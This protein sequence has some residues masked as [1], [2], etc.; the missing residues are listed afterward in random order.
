MALPARNSLA[1]IGAGPVGLEAASVALDRGFDVHVFE[2]GE[3]GTHPL[4]WGHVRMFTP[5]SMNM[6]PSSRARL[7]RSGWRV[8]DE[9]FCPTGAELAEDYL[10][11]LASLPELKDRIHTGAQVVWVSRRGALKADLMGDPRRR[12]FPFRMI[13][14]DTGGREHLLHAYS[15]IDASGVFG[16]PNWAGD[17]GIP[18]R[19]EAHIMQQISYHPDD[20]LDLR[21]GRYAGKR[22]L[23]IGGGTS[24]ATVA[25][26][27]VTL[28]AQAPG[29]SVLWVTR[30][31]VSELF[32]LIEN[33]AL[34]GRRE[35]YE[36]ARAL[37]H[38]GSPALKHAGEVVIEGFEFNAATQRFRVT[39]RGH[40]EAT[41][42]E[43]TRG[44]EVDR[45][46]V[47]AGYGPDNSI[48]R[49]LQ[50]HECYASRGPMM[51]S[52][53]LLGAGN[54]SMQI[55][56]YGADMLANPEPDFYVL[57]HKSY[58]RNPHFLLA[59]GYQQV[60]DVIEKLAQDQQIA[61]DA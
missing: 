9:G 8:R 1:V 14:R 50:V 47:N 7:E 19:G 46:I 11:P 43:A 57:G 28:S 13:A 59:A 22:V 6:G 58:G 52:A 45:V 30:E 20:V 2:R 32:P 39:L 33:D 55:P 60:G 36:T 38:G 27:L 17:G 3:V 5:W 23:L 31:P 21:R 53:A 26:D 24:A 29:T 49:E 25:A 34:P 51:L 40:N 37:L 16:Q 44:E 15:V 10:K 54:D 48:Y 42:T 4:A 61:L 35:L 12:D 18:A 41:G 56:I